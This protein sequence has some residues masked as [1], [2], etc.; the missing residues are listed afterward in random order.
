MLFQEYMEPCVRVAR[1]EESDGQGGSVSREIESQP[2]DAAITV[3]S[4]SD[5]VIS[6]SERMIRAYTITTAVGVNL[7]FFDVVKRL[8]DGQKFRVVSVSKDRTTPERSS[9]QFEQVKAE[10]IDE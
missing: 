4:T 9:F 10:G 3:D 6:A 2:F 7:G 5:G 1:F 8:S